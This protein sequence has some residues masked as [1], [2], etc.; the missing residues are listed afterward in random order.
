MYFVTAIGNQEIA[1]NWTDILPE[2]W[3]IQLASSRQFYETLTDSADVLLR[4]N[5]TCPTFS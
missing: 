1:S 4:F 3:I 2:I 5:D